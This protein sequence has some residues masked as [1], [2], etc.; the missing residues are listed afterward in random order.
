MATVWQTA[1][2]TFQKS[3]PYNNVAM[4]GTPNGTMDGLPESEMNNARAHGLGKG[5]GFTPVG[6]DGSIVNIQLSLI[7]YGIDSN[8]RWVGSGNYVQYG[9]TYDWY[10]DVYASVDN[11]RTYQPVESNI[12]LAKHSDTQALAFGSYW[13]RSTIVWNKDFINIPE[14]FTHIKT[15]IRGA[16]PGERFQN[17]YERR[18]IIPDSTVTV[19][20]IDDATGNPIKNDDIYKVPYDTDYRFHFNS[21]G[22]YV[23]RTTDVTYRIKQSTIFVVRYDLRRELKDITIKVNFVEKGKY[24]IKNTVNFTYKENSH[25]ILTPVVPDKFYTYDN[26][27]DKYI[28]LGRVTSD[29]TIFIYIVPILVYP[30]GV[31]LSYQWKKQTKEKNHSYLR[32]SRDANLLVT[33]FNGVFKEFAGTK[34]KS[35]SK[36]R[37]NNEWVA[38]GEM[39]D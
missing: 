13:D 35:N 27:N 34:T 37:I 30:W 38:Q 1:R 14:T 9:G 16:N 25:V 10:L 7:G 32:Y 20:H 4:G 8:N 21:I 36:I 31:R 11:G 2:G 24:N 29:K 3:G 19:R 23:P 22:N 5:I 18:I 33:D 17:V 28:D 12:L 39:G 15:E 6:T 26:P